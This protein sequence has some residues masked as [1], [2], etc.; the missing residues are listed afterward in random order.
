MLIELPTEEQNQES[1]NNAIQTLNQLVKSHSTPKNIKNNITEM[2]TELQNN[3]YSIS[4]RAANLIGT[5]DDITQDPNI[6][7]YIRTSLWQ[8]VSILESIRE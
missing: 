5:L 2:I 1:L 3:E 8:V 4:V 6:P 7:S